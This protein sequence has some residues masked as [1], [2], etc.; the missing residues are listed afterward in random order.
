MLGRFFCN[1]SVTNLFGGGVHNHQTESP[2]VGVSI[3]E[4]LANNTTSANA[5]GGEG[6]NNPTPLLIPISLRSNKGPSW[7]IIVGFTAVFLC[8]YP[9]HMYVAEVYA[10]DSFAFL[11][12]KYCFGFLFVIFIPVVTLVMEKDIRKG[13]R[14]V[15]GSAVLC[16]QDMELTGN[17]NGNAAGAEYSEVINNDHNGA[18]TAVTTETQ[19]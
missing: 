11:V 4:N 6:G 14:S 7:G 8:T 10:L 13:I 1:S 5:A 17:N 19:P 15:F 18:T 2:S 3:V 16:L 12:V 9:L